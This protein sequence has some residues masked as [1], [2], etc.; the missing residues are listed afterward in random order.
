MFSDHNGRKVLP[1]YVYIN[2]FLLF[3]PMT[4]YPWKQ[5]ANIQSSTGIPFN[6]IKNSSSLKIMAI[7]NEVEGCVDLSPLAESAVHHRRLISRKDEGKCPDYGQKNA[8]FVR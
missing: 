6:L 3:K 2:Y 1:L 5:I 8:Q 7:I 4:N